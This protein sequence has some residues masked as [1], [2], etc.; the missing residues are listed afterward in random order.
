MFVDN[1]SSTEYKPDCPNSTPSVSEP[2]SKTDHKYPATSSAP[3]CPASTPVD[4]IKKISSTSYA[5]SSKP[6]VETETRSSE[7][8]SYP[9]STA[10]PYE[11]EYPLEIG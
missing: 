4:E 2:S 6:N 8:P 1:N 3:Y 10:P 9:T 7:Y 5:S 11:N